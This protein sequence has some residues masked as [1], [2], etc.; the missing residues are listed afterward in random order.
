MNRVIKFRAWSK[1]YKGFFYGLLSINIDA[2][3]ITVMSKAGDV[4][5]IAKEDYTLQQFTG[6][7]DKNGVEIFEGDIVKIPK[8][9]GGD[10]IYPE[11]IAEIIYDL[12][13]FRPR[14]NKD[15]YGLVMQSWHWDEI[16]VIGNIFENPELLK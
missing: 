9:Y 16:E 5:D 7:K 8:N 10:Q 13:C 3:T 2:E 15:R 12:D 11:A 6:L 1:K 4:A 14:D